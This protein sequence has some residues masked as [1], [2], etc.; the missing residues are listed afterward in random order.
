MAVGYQPHDS[1]LHSERHE[2]LIV[3]TSVS[4][5]AL[6]GVCPLGSSRRICGLEAA[7]GLPASSSGELSSWQPLTQ[8]TGHRTSTT[9]M[10]RIIYFAN[11]YPTQVT[12]DWSPIDA[13]PAWTPELHTL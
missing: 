9:S 3:K 1:S 5:L 8:S 10:R 6:Q 2:D 4:D 7:Y 11:L 13:F 12:T